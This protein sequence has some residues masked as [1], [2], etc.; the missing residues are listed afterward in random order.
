MMEKKT[1][2][3]KLLAL[4]TSCLLVILGAVPIRGVDNP[5]LPLEVYAPEFAA[6]FGEK[7][8]LTLVAAGF[9][10]TEGPVYFSDTDNSSGYLIFT[11]QL[12][13]NINTIR[14]NGLRP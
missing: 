14:C 3:Y 7:P 12:N 9:G 8:K 10:F 5:Q 11:D 6:I 4:V 13:D 2:N 1:M